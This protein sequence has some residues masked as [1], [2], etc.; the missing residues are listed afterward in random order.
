M[1]GWLGQLGTS[2]TPGVIYLFIYLFISNVFLIIFVSSWSSVPPPTSTHPTLT[3]AAC[4][5]LEIMSAF[6]RTFSEE[7]KIFKLLGSSKPA[8]S[9]HKSYKRKDWNFIFENPR[10]NITDIQQLQ[11]EADMTLFPS[12]TLSVCLSVSRSIYSGKTSPGGDDTKPSFFFFNISF[13]LALSCFLS[14]SQPLSFHLSVCLSVCFCLSLYTFEKDKDSRWWHFLFNISLSLSLSLSLSHFLSLSLFCLS[15]SIL[16]YLF[17]SLFLVVSSLHL[18]L[19]LSSNPPPYIYYIYVYIYIEREREREN[20][21][22][23]L[24]IYLSRF[25]VFFLVFFTYFTYLFLYFCLSPCFSLSLLFSLSLSI[26]IYIYDAIR[27][28]LKPG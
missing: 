8:L 23:N 2:F 20:E 18:L 24:S 27:R 1:G 21:R 7:C 22:E 17:M 25:C 26:Y 3:P 10:K 9:M 28:K 15:I 5:S 6:R 12:L 13:F 19:P 14:F 11:K 16:R 4:S